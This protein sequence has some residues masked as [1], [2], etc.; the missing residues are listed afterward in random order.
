M[1][2]KWLR[3]VR[4]RELIFAMLQLLQ[5][6]PF[7]TECASLATLLCF[8]TGT[9]LCVYFLPHVACEIKMFER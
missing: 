7:G 5:K 1:M 2:W 9:F 4:V 6:S 8:E 3:D